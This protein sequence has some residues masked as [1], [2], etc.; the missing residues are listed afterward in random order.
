MREEKINVTDEEIKEHIR[1]FFDDVTIKGEFNREF[2]ENA[3][4]RRM[5]R[6]LSHIYNNVN[7]GTIES[8][9]HV[10]AKENRV[11]DEI[12][13]WSQLTSKSMKIYQGFGEYDDMLDEY[14]IDNNSQ[15]VKSILEKI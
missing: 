9:I 12:N 10:I 11:N 14:N 5:E 8:N 13:K 2:L 1:G 3:F 15:I 7:T 6:Y 4:C